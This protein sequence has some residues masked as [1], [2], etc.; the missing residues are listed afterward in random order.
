L[1]DDSEYP[2][3][4]LGRDASGRKGYLPKDFFRPSPE[5]DNLMIA[6]RSYNAR[7]LNVSPKAEATLLEAY[8]G[9]ANIQIADDIGWVPINCISIEDENQSS[10]S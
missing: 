4:F 1:G 8:G 9:W 6:Q 10:S 3:W 5:A 2:E 7:E